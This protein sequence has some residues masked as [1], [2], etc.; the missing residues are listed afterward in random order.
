[1]RSAWI[2]LALLAQGGCQRTQVGF[3]PFAP[4]GPAVMPPPSTGSAGRPDPYYRPSFGPGQ[5]PST[6]SHWTQAPPQLA[7]FTSDQ[8]QATTVAARPTPNR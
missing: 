6:S 8:D 7:R 2:V 3:D 5:P 4:S 1:M